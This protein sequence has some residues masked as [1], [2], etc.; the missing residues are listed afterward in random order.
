MQPSTACFALAFTLSTHCVAASKDHMWQSG[1]LLDSENNSV[2]VGAIGN[3]SSYGGSYSGSAVGVYKTFQVY[4]VDSGTIVY[5]ARERQFLKKGSPNFLVNGQVR[6]AVEGRKLVVLDLDGKEHQAE[7]TEQT[8]AEPPLRLRSVSSTRARQQE[9][10]NWGDCRSGR[11]PAGA[12]C[13]EARP[14]QEKRCSVSKS[15]HI[16]ATYVVHSKTQNHF[17][18]CVSCS[19]R[20]TLRGG[21]S[22]LITN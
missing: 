17:L 9:S 15:A 21:S 1:V 2:P 8:Q 10:Y 3:G 7:I 13:G 22:S 4:V 14:L 18:V 12:D 6:F 5:E 11:Y 16:Q 19:A 20:P